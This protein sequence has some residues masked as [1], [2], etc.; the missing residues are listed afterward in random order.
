VWVL[1]GS[2]DDVLDRL[3]SAFG[4]DLHRALREDVARL[5]GPAK[6]SMLELLAGFDDAF[7]H[8]DRTASGVAE[9]LQHR[10]ESEPD[11]LMFVAAWLAGRTDYARGTEAYAEFAAATLTA[12]LLSRDDRGESSALVGSPARPGE[13]GGGVGSSMCSKFRPNSSCGDQLTLLE[14]KWVLTHAILYSRRRGP[15]PPPTMRP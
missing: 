2:H 10:L 13:R 8:V 12:F 5:L 15:N 9:L 1:E 3:R 7:D 4:E 6:L 11:L 14:Y